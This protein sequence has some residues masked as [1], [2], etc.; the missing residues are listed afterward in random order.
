MNFSD[1]NSSSNSNSSSLS[2]SFQ[3]HLQALCLLMGRVPDLPA[4]LE[5]LCD[6]PFLGPKPD[7]LLIFKRPQLAIKLQALLQPATLAAAEHG[8]NA[9]LNRAIAAMYQHLS[10]RE[11]VVGWAPMRSGQHTS[12]VHIMFQGR[13]STA[14]TA[15]G[16]SWFHSLDYAWRC[17]AS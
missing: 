14:Q 5:G 16:I 1:S 13:L 11:R 9:L 17:R 3:L 8:N 6:K 12:E 2:L 7:Q 15:L 4:V 10:L